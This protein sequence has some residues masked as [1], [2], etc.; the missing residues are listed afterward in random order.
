MSASTAWGLLLRHWLG[1]RPRATTAR[2]RRRRGTMP[3]RHYYLR[4]GSL[5]RCWN[6]VFDIEAEA[7]IEAS[8]LQAASWHALS[9]RE[10]LAAKLTRPRPKRQKQ[11]LPRHRANRPQSEIGRPI[12]VVDL[13][14]APTAAPCAWPRCSAAPPSAAPPRNRR[15]SRRARANAPPRPQ[16]PTRPLR[17]ARATSSAGRVL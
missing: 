7:S 10:A 8:I 12:S 16:K 9:D 1:H 5:L 4:H 15:A 6:L 17:R 3:P 2:S 11:P 14:A 13:G